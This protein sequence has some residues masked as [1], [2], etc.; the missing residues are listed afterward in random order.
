M[1]G[2]DRP[3]K[4]ENIEKAI[5]ELSR[6][7]TPEERLAVLKAW[8]RYFFRGWKRWVGVALS[9]VIVT[10]I[11][12]PAWT[13]L[14]RKGLPPVVV[15]GIC[16]GIVGG[17]SVA[18]LQ[19]FYRQE[20]LRFIRDDMNRKGLPICRECGYDLRSAQDCRCPECGRSLF[21]AAPGLC[22]ILA[23]KSGSHLDE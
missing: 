2:Y 22:S 17:G 10:L 18:L 15:G 13:W 9:G 14:S 8:N 23:Q 11:M 16:G 19:I 20:M 12:L 6:Y 1:F 4:T 5:P 3:K 21:E 7:A